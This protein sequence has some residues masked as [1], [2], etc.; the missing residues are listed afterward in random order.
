MTY[1]YEINAISPK[2]TVPLESL[3]PVLWYIIDLLSNIPGQE[4]FPVSLCP[5][6]PHGIFPSYEEGKWPRSHT[7][8]VFL[9]LGMGY[10]HC[11]YRVTLSFLVSYQ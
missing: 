10:A 2:V 5:L 4:N 11:N 3:P 6:S 1:T 7:A 9:Y 8:L